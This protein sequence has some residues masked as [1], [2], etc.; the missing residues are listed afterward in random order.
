MCSL[1]YPALDCQCLYSSSVVHLLSVLCDSS[2]M[3]Y[4]TEEK[5]K[6]KEISFPPSEELWLCGAGRRAEDM[7][8]QLRPL[9]ASTEDQDT[10]PVC[11]NHLPLHLN[12]TWYLLLASMGICEHMYLYILIYTHTNKNK[13]PPPKTGGKGR[14]EVESRREK[15]EK[16]GWE[17]TKNWRCLGSRFLTFF[18]PDNVFLCFSV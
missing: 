14:R 15:R 11:H 6:G 16:K 8:Q 5:T 18:F 4:T 12:G 13:H 17:E 9:S 10:Y 2:T 7:D 3:P 1:S